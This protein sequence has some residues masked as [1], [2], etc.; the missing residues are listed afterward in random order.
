MI[1]PYACRVQSQV[2]EFALAFYLLKMIKDCPCLSYERC[3]LTFAGRGMGFEGPALRAHIYRNTLIQRAS[4]ARYFLN[5][6]LAMSVALY[7]DVR[8]RYI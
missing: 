5:L 1:I 4:T 2:V 6:F 8:I 7:F 3:P